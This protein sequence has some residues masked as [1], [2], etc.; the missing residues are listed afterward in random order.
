MDYFVWQ[1]GRRRTGW[2][3][4]ASWAEPNYF[5]FEAETSK[6]GLGM[7]LVGLVAD[8]NGVHDLHPPKPMGDCMSASFTKFVF[9]SA[10][11]A[12]LRRNEANAS[13]G[14]RR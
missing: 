14:V 8:L 12:E 1:P 11:E 13:M 7:Q 9:L 10:A 3:A 4:R 5:V 2:Y 6:L